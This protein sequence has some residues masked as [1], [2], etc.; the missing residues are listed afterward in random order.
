M[1]YFKNDTFYLMTKEIN[2]IFRVSKTGHL[3]EL[4]FGAPILN[5]SSMDEDG[6]LFPEEATELH[7]HEMGNTVSYNKDTPPL[8]MEDTRFVVSSLGKGDIR[9]PFI[10]LIYENGSRT[11][12]FVYV[13]HTI[14]NKLPSMKDISVC[15]MDGIVERS[16]SSQ[17][18]LPASYGISGDNNHLSIL[19]KDL[20]TYKDKEK[21]NND[22]ILVLDFLVY[23]DTNIITRS[24]KL[25]NNSPYPVRV[26]RF[27]SN[28]LDF[29]SNKYKITYFTGRWGEE[30][31]KQ[32][33]TLP[34]GRFV[35]SS[36]TGTTSSRANP[37]I[38]ISDECA[39]E[40]YGSVY[41]SNL[42]YSGNHYE[43]VDVSGF[44]KTRFLTGINPTGFSYLLNPTESLR[45]PEAVMTYS[46]EGYRKASLNMQNFVKKHILRGKYAHSPRPILIN[47]WEAAYFDINEEKL[48]NLAKSA[49]DFGIE[50]FVMDDGWFGH[51]DDDTSSLGDWFVNKYKLPNGLKGLCEKINETGLQFGLWIEPEMINVDSELFEKHPEWVIDIPGKPHS[52]GRQQRLLDLINPEVRDY[53]VHSISDILSSANITYVKWDMNRIFSDAYSKYL[54]AK[55]QGEVYHRYVLGF[56][57]ILKRLTE[58]YPDILFEGCSSGGNR[59]DL[60]SLCFF[61]QIWASDDTDAYERLDIQE[62]YSYGYPPVCVSSHIS[63]VPNHQTGRITPLLTRFAVASFGGFGIEMNPADLNEE[64]KTFLKKTIDF[65]KKYRN[66]FQDSSFYK[67]TQNNLHVW[68]YVTEEKD[69][70][71]AA[72]VKEKNTPNMPSDRV[73]LCGLNPDFRYRIKDGFDG[74]EA[75][76]TGRLLM[77]A[78]ICLG[79][80]LEATRPYRGEWS[81]GDMQSNIITIERV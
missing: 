36:F 62:G 21:T 50:L 14:D 67:N 60:A 74:T 17:G 45:S 53:I 30:M 48:T 28:Q 13:H 47:S 71:I 26:E 7:L 70:G 52:E 41:A 24:V 25:E 44:G 10:E 23:E 6:E 27:M 32:E 20:N 76:M 49:S 79:P 42:I 43:S 18:E 54:P 73:Q 72:I 63:A 22:V 15:T 57:D 68:V 16:S 77:E 55:R 9:E 1:I 64:D 29:D 81:H 80:N 34:A 19:L 2:Y 38:F 78:G 12:D 46:C 37:L 75:I 31:Q 59:F 8:S 65:Y 69:K 40:N 58:S 61:P 56:Y 33:L 51:R 39:T 66:I 5:P 4:Y 11:S 35:N 3:I